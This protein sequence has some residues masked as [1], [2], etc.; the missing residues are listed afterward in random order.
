[1][2]R[3]CCGKFPMYTACL[4][5]QT[6]INILTNLSISTTLTIMESYSYTNCDYTMTASQS[7][8]IHGGLFTADLVTFTFRNPSQLLF[9]IFQYPDVTITSLTASETLTFVHP[10]FTIVSDDL[11]SECNWYGGR[12]ISRK[13]TWKS[14]VMFIQ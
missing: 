9:L 13:R 14:I 6:P 8:F 12:T 7:V 4:M 1:M 10:F 5:Y 11:A 2:E 3:I